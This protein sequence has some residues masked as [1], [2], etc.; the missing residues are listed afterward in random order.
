M[1]FLLI[2]E[3]WGTC[4]TLEGSKAHSRSLSAIKTYAN[5]KAPKECIQQP[6]LKIELDHA[7]AD[8]LHL[9]FRISDRLIDALVHRM[10]QL[11]YTCRVCNT[12]QPDHMAK[13]VN[14]ITSCDSGF[15]FQVSL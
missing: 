7:M 8:E 6:L 2:F 14:A 15:P 13:L 4:V 10:A 9:L 12:G 3:R 11:E 5:K 1:L